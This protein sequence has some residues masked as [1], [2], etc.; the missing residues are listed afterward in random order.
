MFVM[1]CF[2]NMKHLWLEMGGG[3]GGS[4]G[5]GRSPGR[6]FERKMEFHFKDFSSF[7][8][9]C[10]SITDMHKMFVIFCTYGYKKIAKLQCFH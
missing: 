2:R 6:E 8:D 5:G 7:I 4:E 3:L 9:S 1:E 10:V